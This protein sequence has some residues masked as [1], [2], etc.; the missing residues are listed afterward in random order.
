MYSSAGTKTGQVVVSS[1]GQTRTVSCSNSLSVVARADLVAGPVSISNVI[2][3]NPSSLTARIS[4]IGDTTAGSSVTRFQRATNASG[5]NATTV[6]TVNT[7]SIGSGSSRTVSMSYTFP[8]SGTFY[9]RACADSS[10]SINESNENNNCGGWAQ[11]S[12]TPALSA[13]CSVS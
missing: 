5:A 11:V 9:V 3:G 7:A 12:V 4:N 2:Q 6:G 10:G 13:S 1:G 8:S